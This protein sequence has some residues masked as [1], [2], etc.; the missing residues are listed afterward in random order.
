MTEPRLLIRLGSLG[1]VVLATAAANRGRELWGDR[2]VDVLVKEE[3]KG[4]WEGH[5][6]V[7]KVLVWPR[8][9]RGVSGLRR[10]AGILRENRYLEAVDLQGSFRTRALLSLAGVRKVRRPRRE[11]LRRR[12]MLGPLRA[13]PHPR[14]TVA[15]NFV[16]AVDA[17]ANAVPSIH[18]PPAAER[19]AAKVIPVPGGVGL[20]PGAR[21][22]TKRWPLDRYVAGGRSLA[23]EQDAVVPVFFGPDESELLTAWRELWPEQDQWKPIQAR[24]STVAACLSRLSTVVTND[25]GLMHVSAA[26]GTPVIAIFGPTV[27]GFGFMPIG[28]GHRVLEIQGLSCRPCSLHGGPRCPKGHFRCMLEIDPARV[29]TALAPG[30]SRGSQPKPVPMP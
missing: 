5:P 19:E 17:G 28:E 29:L 21:H 16:A 9:E 15:R 8:E 30:V 13:N 26:V 18:P 11:H 20:I 3:W 2:C 22:Q 10:W 7:R 12:L 14:F 24:L 1:D 23:R 6:A 27:T 25:T 4:V